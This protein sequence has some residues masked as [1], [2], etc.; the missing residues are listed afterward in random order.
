[1]AP[2]EGSRTIFPPH[3]RATFNNLT[4][5]LCNI[6]VVFHQQNSASRFTHDVR[7]LSLLSSGR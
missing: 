5:P 7:C 3:M 2:N 4:T 6:L 1:R